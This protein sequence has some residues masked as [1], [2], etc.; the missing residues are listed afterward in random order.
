VRAPGHATAGRV[1]EEP[2][3]FRAYSRALGTLLAVDPADGDAAHAI[4]L[5]KAP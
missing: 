1:V 4:D 2:V 3:S 5:A